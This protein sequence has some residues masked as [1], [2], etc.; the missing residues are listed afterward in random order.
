MREKM[1][2]LHEE[3]QSHLRKKQ[4]IERVIERDT[5]H[6][7]TPRLLRL[8]TKLKFIP[9]DRLELILEKRLS[10]RRMYAAAVLI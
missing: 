9:E 6:L 1:R 7:L 10:N 5:K 4:I 3:Y 8:P 2:V